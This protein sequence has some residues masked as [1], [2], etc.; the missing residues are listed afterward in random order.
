MKKHVSAPI[1]AVLISIYLLVPLIM[2]LLY[3]VFSKWNSILPEGFTLR[4]YAE[5]FSDQSFAISLM[6]TILIS[7]LPILITSAVILLTMYVVILYL[8]GLEKYIR[9]LCTIP[10]AIQGVILAVSVLALY[11]NAPGILSDRILLLTGTYCVAILPYMYQGIQ[12]SLLSVNAPGLVEAAQVLGAGKLYAFFRVVVPNILSGVVIS[13]ML[14]A[15]IIFGDFVIA[16]TLGGSYFQ[17]A[18]IYLYQTLFES[19]Q[20]TSAV[21]VVLFVVTL[22]ISAVAFSVQKKERRTK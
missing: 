19:G 15:A 20:R 3:S 13:A 14:S 22:I 6:R 8:P 2:T 1:A 16:N 17:T 12:S 9:I 10:Y 21:I 4:Y 7:I 11:S 5:L 18:Q